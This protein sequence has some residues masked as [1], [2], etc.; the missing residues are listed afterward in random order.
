MSGGSSKRV[1]QT[2]FKPLEMPYSYEV[3]EFREDG[4]KYVTSVTR[5]N[6]ERIE[7]RM[8]YYASGQLKYEATLRG[9]DADKE[10]PAIH[11]YE[12]GA[13][14]SVYHYKKSI[15]HGSYAEFDENGNKTDYGRYDGG[16]R[17][18]SRHLLKK[19]YKELAERFIGNMD[20][21][22]VSKLPA[23]TKTVS[24]KQDL[25]AADIVL[26]GLEKRRGSR[27]AFHPRR[28]GRFGGGNILA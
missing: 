14:Q 12:S 13:V 4:Q 1:V 25:N 5:E 15:P 3:E 17:I 20:D 7:R 22:D 26:R 16:V 6:G 27:D 21:I 2:T 8:N 18:P 9:E 10:G 11:Y 28:R 23:V 19:Q 24:D